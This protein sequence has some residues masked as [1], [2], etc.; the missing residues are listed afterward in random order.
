MGRGVRQP[1]LDS[2]R[3]ASYCGWTVLAAVFIVPAALFAVRSYG[4]RSALEFD[5]TSVL[6]PSSPSGWAAAAGTGGGV[7][8]TAGQQSEPAVCFPVGMPP[9]TVFVSMTTTR[10]RMESLPDVLSTLLDQSALPDGTTHEVHLWLSSEAAM[11]D[12]GTA[13]QDLPAGLLALAER[14]REKLH[15]HFTP[16]IGPQRKL[17]PMLKRLQENNIENAVIVTADDDVLYPFWWLSS[18]LRAYVDTEGLAVLSYSAKFMSISHGHIAP[19]QTWGRIGARTEEAS[20]LTYPEGRDGVLYRPCHLHPVVFSASSLMMQLGGNSDL[21]F[22]LG[23]VAAG[24]N[25]ATVMDFSNLGSDGVLNT[26]TGRAF[27]RPPTL[28][29]ASLSSEAAL[30][31][32]SNSSCSSA[33]TQLH[34]GL[35]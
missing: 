30:E 22:F 25:A 27:T 10:F 1:L 21:H 4:E 5:D 26:R 24:V 34:A 17:L 14:H 31:V 6:D 33:Y 3:T 12:R 13:A 9:P 11:E 19:F 29:G 7:T 35:S 15:I 8:F 18:M 28:A 2:H 16:N 20:I 23:R 32:V